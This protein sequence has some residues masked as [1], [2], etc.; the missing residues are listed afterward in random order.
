V[1][2]LIVVI[3]LAFCSFASASS[4]NSFAEKA[5]QNVDLCEL[6]H[7]PQKYDG[8][9]M[10]VRGRVQFEFEDFTLH[11]PPARRQTAN[12]V[13]QEYGSHSAETSQNLPSSAVDRRAGKQA[14]TSKSAATKGLGESRIR[15]CREVFRPAHSIGRRR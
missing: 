14:P 12:Q 8:Q 7:H 4:P 13:K 3:F 9:M 10:R 5:P 15:D 6:I 2:V 11:G 1:R